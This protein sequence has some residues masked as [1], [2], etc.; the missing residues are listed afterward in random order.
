MWDR[1]G[2]QASGTR[3]RPGPGSKAWRGAS[4]AEQTSGR[5]SKDRNE[6]Q[7]LIAW[8]LGTSLAVTPERGS[9]FS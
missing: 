4:P 3:R 2:W 5:V 7:G 6:A 9:L 1:R 8:D